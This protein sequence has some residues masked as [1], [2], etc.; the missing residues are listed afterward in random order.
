MKDQREIKR[1]YSDD[2]LI[3]YIPIDIN[4]VKIAYNEYF[5]I[6]EMMRIRKMMSNGL[7]IS[8]L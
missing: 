7:V 6:H 8:F 3:L 5:K 2:E 1:K 4:M